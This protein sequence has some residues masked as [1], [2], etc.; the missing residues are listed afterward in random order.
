MSSIW[1]EHWH[2]VRTLRPRLRDG[3]QA[4][5]RRL[6]GRAWVLLVDPVT[7]RFH[8]LSPP[9]WRVL[10][11]LDGRR[12]LDEVWAAACAW[13]ADG[14]SQ[15]APAPMTQTELVQLMASLHANDLLQSQATPDAAEVF[16]RHER[17]A[18]QRFRQSW[19]NPLN[20]RLPLLHPDAW[21]ERR[22]AWA[23]R[24][25]SWPMALLWLALVGPAG[26]LAWQHADALTDN[27]SDRVLS[28]SNLL[29]LWLVYPFVKAVHESAHGLAVKRFGGTVREMGLLFMV[30]TPVPYVD[31]TSSYAFVSK[32]QRALVAAAGIMAELMLGALA[33]YVWLLAEP[34]LVTALAFNVILIAGVSTVLVNGNPLMRYD[35]YFIACDLLEVPNLGQRASQYWTY[36]IDRWL[37]GARD[38]HPP[39]Q[40]HGERLL[41][42]LYGAVS[43]LY[44][45]F[46]TIGLIWFVAAEYRLVGVVMALLALWSAVLLPLWSGWK[47]LDRAASLAQKRES[48]K[49]RALLLLAALLAFLVLVP[50]PFHSVHQAVVWVPDEAIVRV[51]VAGQVQRALVAAGAPVQAGQVVAQLDSPTLAAELGLAAAGL[52][53]VQAQLRRAEVETPAKAQALRDELVS[54]LGKLADAQSRVDALQV[55]PALAGRWVP[56]ADTE[57]AGRYVKRG[58]VL[59]YVVA[60][61]SAVVRTA[62][63]QED[64]DLI[65]SRGRG[66]QVRLVQAM[67][68]AVP[69][70][71]GRQVPAA[72]S[73]LV[74]AALGTAGGGDIA[75]DPGKPGGTHTLRRVFDVQV[76]MARVSPNAVFGDRAY[77]RFDLGPA[78]LAWQWLLRLRQLFLARLNV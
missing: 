55:R 11:L 22:A 76:D 17:H 49:R 38:A 26:V 75:V 77:V 21:F 43:P 35:G 5:H 44:R 2:A 48:A 41:L 63:T 12:T 31:A 47:H 70:Q 28:A 52:A 72:G 45:L 67:A 73:E 62:V 69:A 7:Q 32:W 53:Q 33:V 78:P 39:L 65:R 56:R 6:R 57:L 68:D 10:Q 18:R 71:L 9:L 66:V 46:F 8:R 14:R 36:L 59:G 1:S 60:D 42:L 4:L 34:G 20:L 54:R 30:F 24:L 37:F 3:V 50:L 29:Q 15:A 16:E 74:S 64:M 61:A 27:L 13:P 58:D 19:L 40:V 23:Q 51:Q 25:V